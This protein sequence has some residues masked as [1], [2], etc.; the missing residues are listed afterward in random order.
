LP[1]AINWH[2]HEA[3]AEAEVA[4]DR[5]SR[6]RDEAARLVC[7]TLWSLVSAQAADLRILRDEIAEMRLATQRDYL[8]EVPRD[9][10]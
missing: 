9:R 6:V 3:E 7:A 2:A 10:R 4:A 1:G 5:A 8:G